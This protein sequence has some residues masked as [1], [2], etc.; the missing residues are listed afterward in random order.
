MLVQSP[1]GRTWDL[2]ASPY[3]SDTSAR[4]A[5]TLG[6][7]APP[8][9]PPPGKTCLPQGPSCSSERAPEGNPGAPRL[10]PGELARRTRRGCSRLEL[11][12]KARPHP[13]LTGAVPAVRA[14]VARHVRAGQEGLPAVAA[15]ERLPPGAQ[16]PVLR[17]VRGALALRSHAPH[18]RGRPFPSGDLR[19][20]RG[21][22]RGRGWSPLRVSQ[23]GRWPRGIPATVRS[24]GPAQLALSAASPSFGSVLLRRWPRARSPPL[25][26]RSSTARGPRAACR[27]RQGRRKRGSEMCDSRPKE[28]LGQDAARAGHGHRADPCVRPAQ[29]LPAARLP[30]SRAPRSGRGR[31]GAHRDPPGRLQRS[32]SLYPGSREGRTLKPG[33]WV[34]AGAAAWPGRQ[35]KLAAD[36]KITKVEAPGG[37]GW[38]PWGEC[39]PLASATP[40]SPQ[41]TKPKSLRPVQARESCFRNQGAE[42]ATAGARRQRQG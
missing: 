24:P 35:T 31:E 6:P 7:P 20:G 4:G 19:P 34:L 5:G 12:P 26:R 3:G 1:K 38:C 16:A 21:P 17:R 10:S 30:N 40:G 2:R 33:L 27:L 15:S 25:C 8:P 14:P 29:S 39:W 28:A 23:R 18:G 41:P 42:S 37:V 11:R 36:R 13:P 9:P 32:L 22:R